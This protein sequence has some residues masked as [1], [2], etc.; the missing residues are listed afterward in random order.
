M[1]TRRHGISREEPEPNVLAL[2]ERRAERARKQRPE[3]VDEARGL[4][5]VAQFPVGD[6][7]YAFPLACLRAALPLRMVTPVPLA[8]PYVIGVLR[9]EATLITALSLV[10]VL[11]VRGWHVDP[12]V[13]L[14]VE[15]AP[16]RLVAVDCES[17]PRAVGLPLV[18]VE[19]A[20]AR[21]VRSPIEV[22]TES[23]QRLNLIEHLDEFLRARLE[24][25]HA[26]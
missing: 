26:D 22:V 21:S 4:L 14:V 11:G 1:R 18:V 20:R 16:G 15:L 10:S 3:L 17:V 9:H 8:P 2:L 25:E 23:M 7:T 6:E 13:L 12:A 5:W 24:G 19:D